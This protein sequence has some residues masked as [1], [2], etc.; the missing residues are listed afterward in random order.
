MQVPNVFFVIRLLVNWLLVKWLLQYF[1]N[2]QYTSS[3][4]TNQLK[5]SGNERKAFPVKSKTAPAIAGAIG[6]SGGSPTP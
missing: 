2:N 6:A 3:P 5:R 4:I 1:S